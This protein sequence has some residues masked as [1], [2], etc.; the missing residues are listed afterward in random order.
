LQLIL[1]S[2]KTFK[3]LFFIF[4]AGGSELAHAS[5]DVYQ[6]IYDGVHLD[7]LWANLRMMTGYDFITLNGETYTISKRDTDLD[8]KHFREFYINY[9]Q[10]L[11]VPVQEIPYAGGVHV[12]AVLEGKTKD[13]VICISHYDSY[14]DSENHAVDDAASGIAVMLE[15]AK[16]LVPLKDRLEHTI[17][18][19]IA[20]GE[21]GQGGPAFYGAYI[22]K[23]AKDQNIK[24]LGSVDFDQMGWVSP[25][26]DGSHFDL[27]VRDVNKAKSLIDIA[28]DVTTAYSPLKLKI[29]GLGKSRV[30]A[31]FLESFGIPG[32]TP[33][34]MDDPKNP[35]KDNSGDNLD[36]IAPEYFLNLAKLGATILAKVTGIS[37]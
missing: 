28:T 11:G 2:K 7:S 26:N 17:R 30:D 6:T 15:A 37:P 22:S 13:S 27:Y 35:F 29:A 4:L 25:Q 3:I 14:G 32:I 21:E 19:V 34:E 5:V 33:A 8:K 31:D 18:F 23:L 24:L 16:L 12:E 36:K 1:L 20:D 9:F 10:K